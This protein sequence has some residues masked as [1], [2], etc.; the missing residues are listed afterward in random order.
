MKPKYILDG[1]GKQFYVDARAKENRLPYHVVVRSNGRDVRF[2]FSTL[3]D[4]MVKYVKL[5][6]DRNYARIERV[7]EY[8]IELTECGK[9]YL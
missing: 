8:Y 2:Y 9:R 6:D 4:A 1:S 3:A 5:G 7:S